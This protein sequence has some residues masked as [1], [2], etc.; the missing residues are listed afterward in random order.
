[1]EIFTGIEDTPVWF[2]KHFPGFH[3]IECYNIPSDYSQ[4]P[5]KY[6]EADNRVKETKNDEESENMLK[7]TE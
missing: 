5:E 2:Y 7:Q 4:H 3:N 6:V 1:M